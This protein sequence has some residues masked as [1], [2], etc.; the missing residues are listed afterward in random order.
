MSLFASL[1]LAEVFAFS[2]LSDL[3]RGSADFMEDVE[4]A[5][6]MGLLGLSN[7]DKRTVSAAHYHSP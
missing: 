1:I 3:E 4:Q 6:E 5:T 2:L 7:C